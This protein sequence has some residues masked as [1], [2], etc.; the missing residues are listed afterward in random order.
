MEVTDRE[1]GDLTVRLQSRSDVAWARQVHG[2]TVL[3]VD[4]PGCAGEADALVTTTPGL[5][6]AVRA[7]DCGTLVLST[8]S[9]PW[10]SENGATAVGVAHVGW[11]GARDG[12]VASAA[13]AVR[14]AAGAERVLAWL[15]PCIGPCCYRFG[16]DDLDA[17]ASALG[18][19]V[20]STTADG[21]PALDLPKAVA[22]ATAAAGVELTGVDG[23]C[24]ACS[25]DEAGQ[26]SFF[27]HRARGDV[28]RHGVLAWL[29]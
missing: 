26:P 15:G 10:T 8:P 5:R 25:L 2:A 6:L 17:V 11:R 28:A 13:K 20:R 29:R 4:A 14:E 23:R 1:G 16:E 19:D 27:S 24:T 22:L 18:P 21:E 7:A 9:T 3:V 12:V